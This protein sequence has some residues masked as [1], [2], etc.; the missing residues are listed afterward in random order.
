MFSQGDDSLVPIPVFPSRVFRHSALYVKKGSGVDTLEK[1]RGKRVGDPDFAHTAGI[2]ARGYLMH[3]VGIKLE[4]IEWV[5]A[6]TNKPGRHENLEL[7]LSASGQARERIP[8]RRSTTC[9]SP[10]RSTR[11][12][13]PFRRRASSPAIPTWSG[14]CPTTSRSRPNISAAPASSRSCT[15]WRSSA[16]CSSGTRGWRSTSIALSRKPRNAASRASAT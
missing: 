3:D 9:C 7:K 16:H 10:A 4:E 15:S 11:S 5:Q 12:C 13:R 8:T 14:W 1:L 6:G 2:Y